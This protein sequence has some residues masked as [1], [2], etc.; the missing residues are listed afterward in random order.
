MSSLTGVDFAVV[1]TEPTVSGKHDM[2]RVGELLEKM[3]IPG[4]VII[5]K[6]DLNP[7]MTK[8]IK[9]EIKNYNL[10]LISELPFDRTFTDAITQSKTVVEYDN[11]NI[12]RQISESWEK[13]KTLTDSIKR[14]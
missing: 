8:E 12:K 6:S 7:E 10:E 1:V 14:K 9:D 3:K 2:K 13:I 5:N 4:G 11:G